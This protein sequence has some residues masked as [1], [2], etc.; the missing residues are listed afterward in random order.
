[1]P[2]ERFARSFDQL[3]GLLLINLLVWATLDTLHAEAG[4]Q[5]MLDGLYTWAFYLLVALFACAL[6]ARA[7]SNAADTRGLLIPALSVAPYVL[8][9]FW[10]L[11]DLPRVSARP[12][13]EWVIA[14]VY[15]LLLALRVLRAA[16]ERPTAWAMLIAAIFVVAAPWSLQALNLDTRL[17][18]TAD[19]D[20]EQSDDASAE[21]LLYDQPAR[22]VASV[23]RMAARQPGQPNVF[24]VGF[25]GDGEQGIFKREAL[26]AEQVFADHLGSGEHSVEL[27]NDEDDRDSFPIASASALEQTLKLLASRMD[28]AQDV[29]VLMLTSH[30]S[31]DG[32][33]VVNGSLPLQRLA[34]A[35]LRQ[36][37]DQ[38]GIQWRI[39][40][41]SAC[42]SGV[43]IGPLKTDDTLIVTAAD[44]TH[45]SFGCDDERDLTWFGE[46][47]LQ[48]A[49]PRTQTLEEAFAKATDLIKQREAAAHEVHSNP[50]IWV[51]SRIRQRLAALE[52]PGHSRRRGTI[53]AN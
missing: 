10:L 36:A 31:R 2:P 19:T 42:Y 22:I 23:E 41:V 6:V 39:L 4:S 5:L 27:I 28:T 30:G 7:Q 12:T 16:Y 52:G 49:M 46:A 35:D 25:A 18:L 15:L 43:F 3:A 13:V 53:V 33:A 21:A 48:D 20:E 50:Q 51:G 44:A 11:S 38:S 17:W 14:I 24:F 40:I 8:V 47:F 29:L 1:M 34:P 26:Y 32:L 37:L 9:A 45:S